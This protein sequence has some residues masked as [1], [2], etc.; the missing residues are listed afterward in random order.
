[1]LISIAGRQYLAEYGT[2]AQRVA[3]GN[4]FEH[5]SFMLRPADEYRDNRVRNEPFPPFEDEVK[6]TESALP[7][8]MGI[9]FRAASVDMREKFQLE[10][11][12]V[13]V[14]AVFA[15]SPAQKAG[16]TAGDIIIGLPGQPFTERNFV[17]EW[18]M[19]APIGA[20]Q[21]LQIK[22]SGD[23]KTLS[24]TPEAFPR[25]WP[26][27]PG[28]PEVGSPAPALDGLETFRGRSIGELTRPGPYLLF[29]WATW[30]GPCKAALP[31]LMAFEQERE[32]P[33][34][35]ITD[36]MAE[37]VETFLNK[38]EGPFPEAI[39]LDEIRSSFL[40]YGVSGTPR[41]VFVDE[42]GIIRSNSSGY[43]VSNGLP[44]ENWKW[45]RKQTSEGN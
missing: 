41:F 6:I 27:L 20:A 12:A 18:V 43:R 26:S 4:L 25:T 14:L 45:Q 19:T 5:E 34:V 39:V 30:C 7:G 1:M 28:P 13:S 3:Y 2:D 40:A 35:S 8:W 44:I 9:S 22:R 21:S 23:L 24:L 31:E 33:V 10:D 17:R 16:L 37:S 36:E 15:D 29:F 11:G 32:V 42:Q 38:H